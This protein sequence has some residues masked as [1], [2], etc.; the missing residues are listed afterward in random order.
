MSSCKSN[1]KQ[2]TIQKRNENIIKKSKKY[3][4]N[5]QIV[6]RFSIV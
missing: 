5:S 2:A 6:I 4:K 3:K 1:K